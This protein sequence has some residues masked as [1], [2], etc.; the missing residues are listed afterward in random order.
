MTCSGG[1]PPLFGG[2]LKGL[3]A[4]VRGSV[5]GILE[6]QS[7]F[8]RG[9]LR[10]GAVVGGWSAVREFLVRPCS[11]TCAGFLR[12]R[13]PLPEA[14][15]RGGLPLLRNLFRGFLRDGP[16]LFAGFLRGSPLLVG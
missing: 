1:G 3:S 7:A 14:F 4:R 13:L 11:G 9:F 16:P 10:D 15:L 5:R 12:V 8:V 2:F 6:G